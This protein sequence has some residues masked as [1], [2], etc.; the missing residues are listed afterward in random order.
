MAGKTLFDKIWEKHHIKS[1][2]ADTNL[3]FIDLHPVHEVTSPQAFDSLRINNRVVK[4][5][6]LTLATVDHGIPTS[7]RALGIKDPLSKKQ[8]EALENNCDEFGVTLFGVDD[9]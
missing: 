4:Y 7:N 6:E 1:I 8:I 5:P 3:L 2:D 9:P